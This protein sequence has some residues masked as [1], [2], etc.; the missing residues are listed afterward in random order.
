MFLL[1]VIVD[2][3]NSEWYKCGIKESSFNVDR[4]KN[5]YQLL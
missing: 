1:V 5:H 2:I 3:A 4:F